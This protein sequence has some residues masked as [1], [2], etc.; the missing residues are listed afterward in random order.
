MKYKFY[1]TYDRDFDS[2]KLWYFLVPCFV[3]S[4]IFTE[5]YEFMEILWTLSLYLEAVAIVPQLI[6]LIR[7]GKAES[8]TRDYIGTLGAYRGF[9][10]LNW[11]W[12][13]FTEGYIHPQAF[14]AG[15]IQT[16]LYSEFLYKY[17]KYDLAKRYEL[18]G[19]SGKGL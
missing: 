12:R 2:L 7:K 14:I 18:P 5:T 10:V 6:L 17:I 15:V 13:Y 9:Y 4:L 19:A 8:L 16:A 1:A 11:I 3:V